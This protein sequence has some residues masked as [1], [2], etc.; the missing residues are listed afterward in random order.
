MSDIVERLR[1]AEPLV[2]DTAVLD[3]MREAAEA[4]EQREA[5]IERLRAALTEIQNG[6]KVWEHLVYGYSPKP[7]PGPW[8][9]LARAALDRSAP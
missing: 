2:T 4:L 9:K 3:C 1:K 8:A 5:E 7:F 6:D